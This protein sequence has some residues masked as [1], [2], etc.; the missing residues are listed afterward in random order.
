MSLL[1]SSLVGLSDVTN[2]ACFL[3]FVVE[4]GADRLEPRSH[5]NEWSL[6]SLFKAL[7]KFQ[8]SHGPAVRMVTVGHFSGE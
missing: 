7:C 1:C 3:P 5:E 2:Q 6:V 4:T 8:L